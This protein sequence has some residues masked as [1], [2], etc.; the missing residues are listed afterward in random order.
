MKELLLLF[1][2]FFFSFSISIA[3]SFTRNYKNIF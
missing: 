3:R 2:F 1:S